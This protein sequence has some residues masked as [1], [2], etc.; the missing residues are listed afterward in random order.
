M[1]L[2]DRVTQIVNNMDSAAAQYIEDHKELDLDRLAVAVSQ[3]DYEVLMGYSM[4]RRRPFS[5]IN[6]PRPQLMSWITLNVPWGFKVIPMNMMDS[7]SVLAFEC[8]R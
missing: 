6:A 1:E 7:P 8:N 3:K 5:S 4:G 2:E